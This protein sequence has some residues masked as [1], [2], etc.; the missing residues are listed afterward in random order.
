MF[1]AGVAIILGRLPPQQV[2][3][4]MKEICLVQVKPLVELVHVRVGNILQHRL[5]LNIQERNLDEK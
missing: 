4:A 3:D 2:P 5:S 1:S